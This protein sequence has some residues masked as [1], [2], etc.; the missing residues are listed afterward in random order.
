MP[1]YSAIMSALM[2][3]ILKL[4]KEQRNSRSATAE[5]TKCLLRVQL[6]E[7]HDK[8]TNEGSIPSYAL[9]NWDALYNAYINLGGNGLIKNM[10]KEVRNL[11][12]K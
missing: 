9:E 11:R 7:Y 3:Y 5:G 10:D 2:A 1:V 8:Y 6:I 12:I 4:L